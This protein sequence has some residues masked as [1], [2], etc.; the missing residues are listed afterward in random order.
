MR[1]NFR[2]GLCLSSVTNKRIICWKLACVCVGVGGGALS[3]PLISHHMSDLLPVCRLNSH[4]V[5]L[6]QSVTLNRSRKKT[7]KRKGCD[8]SR[9]DCK[10][11]EAV[12]E[13]EKES[14]KEEE[15][16]LWS[17]F[18]LWIAFILDCKSMNREQENKIWE[19]CSCCCC[20]LLFF[21]LSEINHGPLLALSG[22]LECSGT[23]NGWLVGLLQ[24]QHS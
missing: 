21:F 3:N 13:K 18:K 1:D 14:V 19:Q 17:M 23:Y 20:F 7:L 2:M 22:T 15:S 5:F 12:E 9:K 10:K 16:L 24:K 8:C 4:H 11:K 6:C